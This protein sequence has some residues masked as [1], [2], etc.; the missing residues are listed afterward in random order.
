MGSELFIQ[1]KNPMVDGGDHREASG[2]AMRASG[3]SS[4]ICSKHLYSHVKVGTG[5]SYLVR[6]FDVLTLQEVERGKTK[7]ACYWPGQDAA[8]A[9]TEPGDKEVLTQRSGA[10]LHQQLHQFVVRRVSL[11]QAVLLY[12]LLWLQTAAVQGIM[13]F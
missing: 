8:D 13:S 4:S 11:L 2:A 7:C 3:R 1:K 10:S 5:R 9:N 6:A 12:K